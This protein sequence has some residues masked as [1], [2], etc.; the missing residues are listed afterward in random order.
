MTRPVTPVIHLSQGV[1]HWEEKVCLSPVQAQRL[2]ASG[3]AC[4]AGARSPMHSPRSLL[5]VPAGDDDDIC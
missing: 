2:T 3:Q 5:L 1:P 4:L